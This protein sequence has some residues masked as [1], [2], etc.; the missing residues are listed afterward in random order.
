MEF[1]VETVTVPS[2]T[3][4][5][6]L[7]LPLSESDMCCKSSVCLCEYGCVC[8]F[9]WL[10]VVGVT[11]F[12]LTW[13]FNIASAEGRVWNCLDTRQVQYISILLSSNKLLQI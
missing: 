5:S 1:V 12:F 10:E 9:V 4:H 11:F 8:V 2:G 13:P 6:T 7:P 3:D